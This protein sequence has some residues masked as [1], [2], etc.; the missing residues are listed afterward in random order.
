MGLKVQTYSSRFARDKFMSN[1][2]HLICTKNCCMNCFIVKF[3][4][5]M[6]EQKPIVLSYLLK[7]NS[8]KS[9]R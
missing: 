5:F 3:K 8:V 7:N 2:F 4:Y 9:S 6:P 1:I